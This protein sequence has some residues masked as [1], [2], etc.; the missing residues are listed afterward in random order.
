MNVQEKRTLSDLVFGTK[1]GQLGL[2]IVAVVI[3]VASL[4]TSVS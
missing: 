2:A 3:L 4:G 1:L